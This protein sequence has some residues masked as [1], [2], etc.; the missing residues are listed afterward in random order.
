[1]DLKTKDCPQGRLCHSG[2]A[3]QDKMY[4]FGGHITQPA[5]EYFHSVKQDMY[6]YSAGSKEWTLIPGDVAPKRTEHS[7]I[8]WKDS[9]I[10]FGGYSGSSYENSLYSFNFLAREWVQIDA[11][12]EIPS[13]RSAHTAVLVGDRMIVFGGWNGD[14]C[15][16]DIFELDLTSNIW[17]R[18]KTE[19]TPPCS[20]CSHGATVFNHQ[21][22]DKMFIFGGYATDRATVNGVPTADKGYLNDLHELN[23]STMTW[24]VSRQAG[25]VPSPRSR[26]RVAPH[27]NNLY[28]FGGWNSQHHFGNLFKLSLDTGFW[29]EISS[30]FDRDGL[31][32]FSLCVA[33]DYMYIFAGYS[34]K[35][36]SRDNLFAYKLLGNMA[37]AQ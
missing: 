26:F 21:S 18:L 33:E 31:G 20:R 13:A 15:M 7:A 16:N 29:T 17:R 14:N 6:E 5:T 1:V 25:Q 12:G 19:G 36:G 32:Q 35:T 34:P 27:L 9:M 3:H 37:Q 11:K 22:S 10:L 30:D 2:V 4:V 23:L 8:V 24:K 28:L